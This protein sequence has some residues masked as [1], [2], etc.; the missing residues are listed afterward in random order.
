[1]PIE[2]A[3]RLVNK[4]L[5]MKHKYFIFSRAFLFCLFQ[6][7]QAFGQLEFIENKG[8]WSGSF[9]LRAKLNHGDM[10][11]EKNQVSFV[12]SD[13]GSEIRHDNHVHAGKLS[14][15]KHH[16]YKMEFLGANG[17][18]RIKGENASGAYHNYFSSNDPKKWAGKVGLFKKAKTEN[19]YGGIDCEWKEEN[20]NLKYEFVV[21]PGA[22]PKE[23]KTR[24]SGLDGLDLENGELIL[25]TSLGVITEQKPFAYQVINK[26]KVEVP[27]QFKQLS[28]NEIGFDFPAGFNPKETLVIDPILVFSSFSGSRSNNW[29]FTAAPGENGATY[30]GGIAFG[31]L[32][33]VT[34]G[35]F[36]EGYNGIED[37]TTFDVAILKYNSLGTQLLYATYLGGSEAEVPSSIVMDNQNN[38]IILGSTSS[39]NFPV[40]DN[41][42]DRTFN[43][44]LGISPIGAG[45]LEFTQGSDI[46]ISKLSADG[47]QLLG[48]TFLGGSDNDGLMELAD[49]STN[50]LV[51]N[52][53]DSFRGEVLVDSLGRI[54]IA[55][56]TRSTNFPVVQALQASK[57]SDFDA[58]A[59]I[60]NPQLTALQFSTYLG[61]NNNDAAY[62][63]QLGKNGFIYLAGGTASSN[64]RT[65][66]NA[67]KPTYSGSIDGFVCKFSPTLGLASYRGTYLGTSSYDQGYFVQLDRQEKV[68][69]FGQTRGSYP[70]SNNVY[71]NPNS[72][73]FIHCL[74][75]NLDST[76]FS[77]TFGT[78]DQTTNISPTAFLVDDCGRIYCSGWG[79]A[80]NNFGG[81]VNGNTSGMPVS[82]DAF[83]SNSDGSDF[84]IL[85]LERNAASLGF[86]TFFGANG[87]SDHVDGGTS[88]FDKKGV[89]HQSVCA[90]GQG[91]PGT[92]FPF[93]PGVVSEVNRSSSCNNAVFKYDFSLLKA[94]YSPSVFQA[95]APAN[96]KFSSQSFFAQNY[97]WDFR[98]GQIRSTTS[99]TISHLF[100]SAGTF[101]VKLIALNTEA[102][103]SKDSLE[104]TIT[105]Q[106]SPKFS[107]DSLS[108]CTLN[109]TLSF[110][111]LPLGTFSYTWSPANFLSSEFIS[112]PKII[113]PD[114]TIEYTAS[115]STSL[116]C[117]SSAKF[118]LF[119]RVLQ[120]KAKADTVKGCK[121]F[122]VN[123]ENKSYRSKKSTW[124]WGNGD[125]I[126]SNSANLSFTFQQLGTFKVVLKAENDTSCQ[127]TDF[128]TL[129]IQV[130]D[131]PK[132]KDTTFY[133][134][135]AGAYNINLE[136]NS[137][138]T[139]AWTPALGLSD[140]AILNPVLLN[141]SPNVYQLTIK[142]SNQCQAKAT[143][144]IKDG[145][146]SSQALADT[147]KGCKPLIVNFENKSYRSEKS[148]WFWGNGDSTVSNSANL[149]F[150]FQQA[151]TFKV[152]LKAENDT[153]C[154]QK[155]FDTLLVQVFD[156]PKLKDT[157][158][159]YCQ[160]GAYNI[161]LEPN[162]AK[163]F[164]WTPA[165]LLSDSSVLN[166]V[167][168]SP[169][170]TNF[171]LT[172][173][174]SN[175]CQARAAVKIK[176][177]ILVS[178][179]KAD[180]L[181]G[182]KPF[183]LNLKNESYRVKT[184]T[185]FWGNGDSTK[186]NSANLSYS[187]QQ[188]GT[189]KVVLK[190]EN[191]TSCKKIDFDTLLVQVFEP[192][193]FL[194][195]LFRFC[196]DGPKALKASK[197]N[198]ISTIW[199]PAVGLSDPNVKDPIF[200]IPE[201]R[202]FSVSITDSN[203][204]KSTAKVDIRDGR[205]NSKFGAISFNPCV[206]ATI[207]LNNS[208]TNPQRSRWIYGSDSIDV[209]GNEIPSMVI[210]APG[211]LKIKLKVFNDTTCINFTESEQTILLGGIPQNP[212]VTKTFCP[213]DS[214]Q[215][216]A[217]KQVGYRFSW[218][219]NSNPEATD[220][221][222]A[223]ILAVDS[224]FLKV[225][226]KD[227][228]NCSG[229]Q[230]FLLIPSRPN[231]NFSAKSLFEICSDK[232]LYEFNAGQTSSSTTYKW[233]FGESI[234]M[235]GSNP[236]FEFQKRGLY[237]VQLVVRQENCTDTLLKNVLVND[238]VLVL[239]PSFE[240][241][242][243]VLACNQLPAIKV[244][245]NSIGADKI[246]WSW[247]GN[248]VTNFDP[249][250]KLNAPQTIE[251]NLSVFKGSCLK[252]ITK[253]IEV[254][255][256]MPPNLLTPNGDSKNDLFV[257]EN[258]PPFCKLKIKNRWG[259]EI[260]TTE[261]Y[262]N[263]WSPPEEF[264]TGFYLL[265]LP[266]GE[267]CS[268]WLHVEKGE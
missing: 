39:A 151:G 249:D 226:I 108:F 57:S 112:K 147:L 95:C 237:P 268:S 141:P 40:S 245:N 138:K 196:E 79:G 92:S 29:G 120:S 101:K 173:K 182:C 1:L 107:G 213:G 231:A 70:V 264:R 153:A 192:P 45:S 187:F 201:P 98:D 168:L 55:S 260:F 109:D 205:L 56:N 202:L 197:N 180:T 191:D 242:R 250:I 115:V 217:V 219:A 41:A 254:K 225:I 244:K 5:T 35:A 28:N 91:P 130:F 193:V 152:V 190:V 13:F 76:R 62:S 228:L 75:N 142:D 52:Y 159:Y 243:Q 239:E 103:P 195:T 140:S 261:D 169:I 125:S 247:D 148:T 80:V 94:R 111:G 49:V 223:K 256:V 14:N 162:S 263:N 258:L 34:T 135:Q 246:V 44:G 17:R 184:S 189:F 154:Q 122:T 50:S 89:I 43:G 63:I 64:F 2:I 174:D 19:I 119:N 150:T 209:L 266:G 12:L 123:F 178:K 118:K 27:C 137:A 37:F 238:S 156:I 93:T 160:T 233:Q 145:I 110:T 179:A 22:D 74:S 204:C 210:S 167:F 253:T 88:R 124:F 146:L 102:C 21:K 200:L 11:L 267:N 3:N 7:N 188:S 241:S 104:R 171:Q 214:V 9:G 234:T 215:L 73:Q 69:V 48:S 83:I 68:Y 133:Y 157:T 136:P 155:D 240:F 175:Q 158:L 224:T 82:P 181:K 207:N 252:T 127:K 132:L 87:G 208:S 262:Q 66:A 72:G 185:W 194:D 232:L 255:P 99:D 144:K 177:G 198:G 23:I 117:K 149:S 170:P 8:Q 16:C 106:K 38:L 166:P 36:Q 129:L 220:S 24:Y 67:L 176:D 161:N 59:A 212:L 229:F 20:G 51:K 85:V 90:C 6:I 32:F 259:E 163:T 236:K 77:T 121:P 47:S 105:I 86:A 139:F 165:L 126:V 128:D 230:D 84:Y 221:S 4:Q 235:S 257:I 71:A 143:I 78:Q 58:V 206:P 26:I 172:I 248:S 61:G 203:Q 131:N 81:Y 227:S 134:C 199:S 30:S 31:P 113:K 10:W 18:A 46:F 100:D 25:K 42:Y 265:E 211:L 33:P 54:Y 164:A 15:A 65:T 53:G 216:S 251:M 114:S 116:G 183:I 186:I 60:F 218:P 97:I 222:L 96:I